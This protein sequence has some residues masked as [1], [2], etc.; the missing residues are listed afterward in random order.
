MEHIEHLL[1]QQPFFAGLKPA[2]L[3]L[4]AGCGRNAHFKAGEMM[5]RIGEPADEFFLVREGAVRIEI[6]SPR[7]GPIAVETVHAGGML[8]WSWL[9]PPYRWHFDAQVVEP[10]RATVLDGKCLRG[11]FE[12]DPTLG[13]AIM[14]RFA[15]VILQRLQSTTLQ[16]IEAIESAAE[17]RSA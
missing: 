4:I 8:G 5:L 16:F 17:K 2:Q 14:Q 7:L 1:A 3:Q 9:I 13:Y 6:P 15:G 12:S 10:V 11:K